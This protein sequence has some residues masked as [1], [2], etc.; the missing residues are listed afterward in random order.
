MVESM[1]TAKAKAYISSLTG[2]VAGRPLY[3]T[4]A[5]KIKMSSHHIFADENRLAAKRR[6]MAI[7]AS[8]LRVA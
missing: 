3:H 6:M 4:N 5:G 7:A 2:H 8:A 1:N